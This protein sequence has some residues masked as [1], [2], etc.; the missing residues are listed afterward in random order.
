MAGSQASRKGWEAQVRAA[1]SHRPRRKPARATAAIP[2]GTR[3]A[4]TAIK[5]TREGGPL[6][7]DWSGRHA[8]PCNGRHQAGTGGAGAETLPRWRSGI[9]AS[10]RARSCG[11][12]PL[13]RALRVRP[14]RADVPRERLQILTRDLEPEAVPR[15]HVGRAEDCCQ[16]LTVRRIKRNDRLNARRNMGTPAAELVEVV[17]LGLIGGEHQEH[18][19]VDRLG[20]LV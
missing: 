10:H 15:V 13:T 16:A 5:A 4:H 6:L 17:Q 2:V 3:A 18:G 20:D 7:P 14:E 1:T 9:P 19:L 8:E 11:E 12:P